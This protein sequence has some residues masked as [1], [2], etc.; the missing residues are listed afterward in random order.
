MKALFAVLTL[1]PSLVT[2][3]S[4]EIGEAMADAAFWSADP[5]LFVKRHQDSGFEFT[6][7]R[8]GGADSRLD[9]GVTCFGLPV[10]ETK[11]VFGTPG[12]VDRIELMLFAKAGTES[13]REFS[14]GAGKR[15]RQRIR[16]DKTIDRA[17]FARILEVVRTRLTPTGAKP[18]VPQKV[19]GAD[20]SE[21]RAEQTWTKSALSAPASLAWAFRQDGK[22]VATFEP[23]YVRLTVVAPNRTLPTK[24]TKAKGSKKISD[25]VVRDP[26]GDVFIG[27][28]PMVDQGQKGYCSVA[29]AERVLR[30]YGVDVDEHEI[31]QAAGTSPEEGTSTLAMKRSVEAIGRKYRLGTVVCYGDFE[32][33]VESR[34]AGLGDE[35]KAY[36]KAAKKLK[37]APITDDMYIRREGNTI[38]YSPAAV[39]KAMDAEVLKEMKVNGMQKSKY[40]RFMKDVRDQ[41]AKGVPLFW[42]VTLGIYPEPGI[43]QSGGGHMRLIVGY[44]DRQHEILYTDSWGAGHELKRMPADWAWT[45][46]RCLLYMKPLVR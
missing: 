32:K 12:G 23:G 44:N 18:G 14:D 6:S 20:A 3:G 41:V 26:R 7:D 46:S 19:A 9:G 27:E 28:V 15:F 10:F 36:N 30:Y 34:I 17:G 24:A 22:D 4:Y 16:L 45:I 25:N 43:P 39:D 40:T 38:F 35:V 13:F 11:V 1:L 29:T 37:A 2:A 31:A 5:V 33:S 42:G 8:R 21:R